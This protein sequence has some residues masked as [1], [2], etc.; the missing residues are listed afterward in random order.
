MSI[1][2]AKVDITLIIVVSQKMKAHIN[3]FGLRVQHGVLSN[4]NS[5]RAV[6]KQRN[7]RKAQTKITQ[8]GHHPKQLG[9]AASRSNILSLRGRLGDTRLLARRPRYKRRTNKLAGPRSGL[10]LNATTSKIGIGIT[11]KREGGGSRIPNPKFWRK[12]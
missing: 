9:T 8:S 6:T 4:A 2:M 11:A 5:T 7:T 3:V 10:A 1:D 12:G